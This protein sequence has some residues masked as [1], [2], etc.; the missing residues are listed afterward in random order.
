[1]HHLLDKNSK[2]TSRCYRHFVLFPV[3]K[4]FYIREFYLN[5]NFL[6]K[7][8]NANLS[9]PSSQ[10]PIERFLSIEINFLIFS[11]KITW[12]GK[13]SQFTDGNSRKYV[14][15]KFFE[16]RNLKMFSLL[17]HQLQDLPLLSHFF[18]LSISSYTPSGISNSKNLRSLDFRKIFIFFLPKPV[19]S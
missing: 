18:S 10:I 14:P 17:Q 6:E 12:I 5:K 9:K 8:W 19:L 1:M 4:N 11:L 7:S 3:C 16:K 13:S 15:M 2:K